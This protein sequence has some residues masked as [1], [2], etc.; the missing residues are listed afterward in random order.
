MKARRV[1]AALVAAAALGGCSSTPQDG[2]SFQSS[3][4]D[5][6]QTVSVPVFEN[7]TLYHGVEFDLTEAIVKEI[8]RTTPWV[9]TS[10]GSAQTSLRGSVTDAEL[11]TFSRD[12]DTGLVM[13]Q[14][15]RLTIDFEWV[16]NRSGEILLQRRGFSATSSFVPAKPSGERIEVAQYGAIDELAG[17]VVGELRSSW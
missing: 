9:V 5:D 13:E 17:D 15:Y 10:A 12:R 7:K 6:V 3:F 8:Q 4:T 16:D 14:G 1:T 11:Q 2:Y